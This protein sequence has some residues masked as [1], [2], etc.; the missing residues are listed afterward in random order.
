MPVQQLNVNGPQIYRRYRPSKDIVLH[1]GDCVQLLRKMPPRSV[2]LVLTSPPYC[3][4]KQY[5]TATDAAAFTELHKRMIDE[6]IRVTK[7]AGNICWQVGY[8]VRSR[9]VVPLDFLTY[10][11]FREIPGVYLRNRLIWTFGHGHHETK[12]FSGRHEVILWFSKGTQYYF[13]LD[14]V[15]VPQKYPGKRHYKGPQIG[16]FSGNPRGKNPSDV[17]DIPHVKASH[18]EKTLHPCQFPIGLALRLIRSLCPPGGV[19]LDPF[20]GSGTTGAAAILDGRRFVGAEIDESYWKI[21]A[22][23][24]RRAAAGRLKYRSPDQPVQEATRNGRVAVKP[25]HFE[26]A[27]LHPSDSGGLR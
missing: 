9:I 17:W 27:E 1:L 10:E 26:W 25:S 7:D 24:L 5:D 2:D 18:P 20:A 6:L 22:H 15:R 19:V 23:R 13:D 16:Q 4:G 14:A 11:L 3:L 8:H 12:R 21:A